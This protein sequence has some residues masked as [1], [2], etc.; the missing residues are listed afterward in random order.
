MLSLLG[1]ALLLALAT[2]VAVLMLVNALG[3]LLAGCVRE[4]RLPGFH[5][6]PRGRRPAGRPAA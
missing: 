3:F 5:L 4:A 6:P 2:L 1:V